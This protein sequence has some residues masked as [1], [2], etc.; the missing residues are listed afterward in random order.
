MMCALSISTHSSFRA[1]NVNRPLHV[2][3]LDA[4][5]PSSPPHALA[6]PLAKALFDAEAPEPVEFIM[7]LTEVSQLS[8]HDYATMWSDM[9]SIA[10]GEPVLGRERAEYALVAAA[11][12]AQ[13]GRLATILGEASESVQHLVV[14][15]LRLTMQRQA[16]PRRPRAEQQTAG[17]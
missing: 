2:S 1:M 12:V 5:N 6:E 15:T 3:K 13:A 17:V 4:M 16:K 11:R 14:R 10:R 8:P 9:V 7:L